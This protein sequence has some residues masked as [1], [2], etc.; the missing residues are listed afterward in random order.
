MNGVIADINFVGQLK[1][2]IRFLEHSDVADIWE[3]LSLKISTFQEIGLNAKD[4][5]RI[6]WNRCQQF[7]L[8]LITEN[9]N[10]DGV[11]SLQAT[12][13]DSNL[14][15]SLP[16]ITVASAVRVMNDRDYG[17]LIARGLLDYLFDIREYPELLLGTGRQFLPKPRT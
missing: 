4:S 15:H 3:R 17:E 12:I 6:V 10:N 2:I 5:D 11:D 16:V 9:R 1:A 8:V 13:A 14:P 7:K